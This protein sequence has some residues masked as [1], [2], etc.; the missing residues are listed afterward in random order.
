MFNIAMS[1][2]V[3]EIG[4]VTLQDSL[5]VI[6]EM[7]PHR[8]DFDQPGALRNFLREKLEVSAVGEANILEFRFSSAEPRVSLMGVGAMRDAFVEYQI[9]SRKNVKAVAYYNEQLQS[10]HG[11][12]DSLL[13]IRS[14]ILAETGYTSIAHQMRNEVGQLA[15]VNGSLLKATAH[16]RSLEL[17]YETLKTYLDG[18]P[19]DFPIG[20]EESRSPTLVTWRNKVGIHQ[21]NLNTILTIHTEDSIPAR[22]QQ[23]LVEKALERL[24]QEEIAYVE[25]VR[26]QLVSARGYE[27]TLREQIEML[28]LTNA[29]APAVESRISLVDVEVESLRSLLKDIQGKLGEVRLSQMADERVS[30][31]TPLTEPEMIIALSGGKTMVYF[32]MIILFSLALGIIAAFILESMDHRVYH[33]KDIEDNLQLPVFASVTRND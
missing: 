20:L 3:A 6:K 2:P 27:Q 10:V 26:F 16:R 9:Y 19:L 33:P 22:R 5:S 11:E 21:D 15:D 23:L 13:T 32:V 4:A 30:T 7:L 8:T 28:L 29:K 1:I 17:E 14:E 25:S 31:V 12:I 24:R 18:N